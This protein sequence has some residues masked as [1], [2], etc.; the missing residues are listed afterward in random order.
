MQVYNGDITKAVKSMLWFPFKILS[1][2]MSYLTE[3][4][5]NSK[6]L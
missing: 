6:L 2:K 5:N 4:P 1:L 3:S